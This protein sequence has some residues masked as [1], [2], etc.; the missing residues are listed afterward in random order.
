MSRQVLTHRDAEG[1]QRRLGLS[2]QGAALPDAPR[3]DEYTD[4]LF[5]Y[6]PAEV[7][8]AYLAVQGIVQAT[9][10][11]ALARTLYWIAFVALFVMTPLYL[12]RIQRVG[13]TG[14]LVISSA[15]F[16]VWVLAIGGP[17]DALIPNGRLIGAVAVPLYTLLAAIV[18]VER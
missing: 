6:I 1:V 10:D 18:S 5:Q 14:Q 17:F 2:A 12:W 11:A 16:L 8:T 3:A 4:R 7:V 15:A 9:A 13:K